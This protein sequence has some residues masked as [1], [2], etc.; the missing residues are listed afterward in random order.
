L[1]TKAEFKARPKAFAKKRGA[2]PRFAEP[3][4]YVRVLRSLSIALL[5]LTGLGLLESVFWVGSVARELCQWLLLSS[6]LLLLFALLHRHKW[7]IAVN[8]LALVL[9]ALPLWPL[10]RGTRPTPADGP[11]LRVASAT[12]GEQP[13]T[14]SAVARFV[15]RERLDVLALIHVPQEGVRNLDNA[16][17]LKRV[18]STGPRNSQRVLYA[19]PPQSKASAAAGREDVRRVRVGRCNVELAVLDLPSLLDPVARPARAQALAGL[20]RASRTGLAI[21]L[22]NLGGRADAADLKQQEALLSLRDTREG[23]GLLATAP[24]ALGGFGRPV[25][26]AL[27]Q[28]WI[29]VRER[30]V[31]APLAPDAHRTVF[32]SLELTD[33]RCR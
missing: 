6:S 33:R 2:R 16:L 22:G 7:M 5:V 28:G 13:P 27:V 31:K 10:Y 8:A 23:H 21:W 32:A 14:P 20:P 12:F 26:H 29:A 30:S 24:G 9:C 19:R 17:P 1:A 18:I 3:A 11:V 25:D 15:A 4:R